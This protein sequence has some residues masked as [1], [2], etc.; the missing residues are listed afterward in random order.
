MRSALGRILLIVG[1]VGD[2]RACSATSRSPSPRRRAAGNLPFV[3]IMVGL[4]LATVVISVY[5]PVEWSD[6][7][8]RFAVGAPAGRRH[9]ALARRA[10]DGHGLGPRGRRPGPVH[11]A[12]GRASR[13]SRSGSSRTLAFAVAGRLGVGPLAPPPPALDDGRGPP[14]AAPAPDGWLRLGLGPRAAG[15]LAGG[16]PAR[17]PARRV[18]ASRTCR[19]PARRQPDRGR[20]GRRATPGE[21]LIELTR[22][23]YD[24]H[25]DLTRPTRR[26]SPWWAWPLDLKPVWFYQRAR[27]PGA[28]PPRSTTPATW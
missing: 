4:T 2:H 28:P 12:P 3:L 18:R 20:P 5:R 17:D 6:D 14:P 24:Y 16:L 19:G 23:M 22:R 10:R 15:G 27:T 1:L 26:R 9:P 21:T 11:A 7:E 8:V 25:N 13:W